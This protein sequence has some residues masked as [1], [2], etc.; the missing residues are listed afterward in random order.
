MISNLEKINIIDFI[1]IEGDIN[2]AIRGDDK[3]NPII[4]DFKSDNTL[5][6][7][8]TEQIPNHLKDKFLNKAIILYKTKYKQYIK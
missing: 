3:D 5:S 7:D 2:D 8:R 6:K 1:L 4:I